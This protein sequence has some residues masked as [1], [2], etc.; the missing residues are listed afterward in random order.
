MNSSRGFSRLLTGFSG[1]ESSV[2]KRRFSQSPSKFCLRALPFPDVVRWL[3]P[4]CSC[5][6]NPT[7]LWNK[8]WFKNKHDRSTFCTFKTTDSFLTRLEILSRQQQQLPPTHVRRINTQKG[9]GGADKKAW[10]AGRQPPLGGRSGLSGADQADTS[11][12]QR[13]PTSAPALQWE[14]G[15][16]LQVY[17]YFSTTIIIIIVFTILLFLLYILFELIDIANIL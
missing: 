15:E 17:L 6:I 1:E 13:P 8:I 12:R 11:R 16:T 5:E 3:S 7:G 2:T 10:C 9:W 4:R 14:H